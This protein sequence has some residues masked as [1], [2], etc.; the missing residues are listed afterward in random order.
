MTTR[1]SC[2]GTNQEGKGADEGEPK[3]ETNSGNYCS[4]AIAA[5]GRWLPLPLY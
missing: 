2:N 5:G 3:L 1:G 4:E